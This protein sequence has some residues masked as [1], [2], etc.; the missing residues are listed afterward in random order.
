MAGVKPISVG[1]GPADCRAAL[2]EYAE[3]VRGTPQPV[4][5]NHYGHRLG[6]HRSGAFVGFIQ[7]KIVDASGNSRIHRF[8]D[9]PMLDRA[10]LLS[11]TP[12]KRLFYI[13]RNRPVAH[14]DTHQRP[15]PEDQR[16][17]HKKRGT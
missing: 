3:R 2:L 8:M 11:G 4:V 13:D 15:Q 1:G 17:S 5:S 14:R 16:I 12:G 9:R 6:G 10:N 7:W